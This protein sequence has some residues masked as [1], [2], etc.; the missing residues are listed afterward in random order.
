MR[1]WFL[2]FSTCVFALACTLSSL[3]EVPVVLEQEDPVPTVSEDAP[4]IKIGIYAS[5]TGSASMLGQ[6]GQQ[7][8]RLAV[9]QINSSGGINGKE[10]RLIEYDDQTDPYVATA[11]VNKMIYEDGV[12]AIIGSHTSGNIIQTVPV[13]EKA[14]VL[15]VGLGTSYLWTNQGYQ[16]LFRST[17]NSQVYDDAL[18]AAIKEAGYKRIALYYCSTEYA[19]A[20]A[21]ALRSRIQEDGSMK[22]VWYH[23]NDI[24]QTDF[25]DDFRSMLNSNPDAVIL[26]A[27][28][29]NAGIQLLQ[30]REDAK[31][32]GLVYGPEAYSNITARQEAGDAVSGL[33][34]ACTNSIPDSP[35][36]ASSE[37][38]RAFLEQHIRMYGTMPTSQTAYRGYDAIMILAEVFRTAKSMD[39]EDLREAMLHIKDFQG[40]C[41]TYDFSDGSGDGLKGCQIVTMLNRNSM[42]IEYYNPE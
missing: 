30:L 34:Y 42:S 24:D 20:G 32:Y 14:H 17:G 5:L 39:R 21:K 12:A 27:S 4:H 36:D 3:R 18:F 33:V 29:E 2:L 23:S 16:Y 6:M 9:D 28:S 10:I 38:E 26:Y 41:G 1:K 37:M 7:G 22:V 8:C 11:L 13:T 40:I 35:A 15:Q 25:L 19:Q 31:Y